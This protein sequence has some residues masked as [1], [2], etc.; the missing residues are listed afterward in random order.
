[1]CKTAQVPSIYI[2]KTGTALLQEETRYI[3]MGVKHVLPNFPGCFKINNSM[4]TLDDIVMIL[5]F[6][7]TAR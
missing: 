7:F 5:H 3:A 2:S 1:M 4:G 6:Y